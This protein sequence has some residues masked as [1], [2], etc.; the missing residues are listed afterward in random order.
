MGID[1]APF[2]ANLYLYHYEHKYM[3]SLMKKDPVSARKFKYASRFI[4]DDGNLNDQGEFGCSFQT[5][6]PKELDLK[7]EHQG[8]HA[9]FLDMEINIVDGIFVYKLFDKRDSFPFDIVR[10]PNLG[11]NI[12]QHIFYGSFMAEILRIGRA[13]LY[14]LDFL[15]RV[16]QLYC[17]MAK[18]GGNKEKAP[19]SH[20]ENTDKVRGSIYKVK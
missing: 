7:C 5:I 2:W 15:T 12:P 14:Y 8:T 10:M 1:P 16:K 20:R 4:D 17:R 19:T 9:T 6:Y 13:T 3:S 18:Q 11:G